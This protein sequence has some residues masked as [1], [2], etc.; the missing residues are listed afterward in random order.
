VRREQRH[1]DGNP[2]H[3]ATLPLFTDKARR[4]PRNAKRPRLT[5]A[6]L[7][8]LERETGFEPA[9]LSEADG[10]L[11]TVREVAAR[12]RVSTATVYKLCRRGVLRHVRVLNAV[13]IAAR[14]L[15]AL[16]ATGRSTTPEQ[17]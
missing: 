9:T 10:R 11:L 3:A 6:P 4:L 12:L 7:E 15:D 17:T 2:R 16:A 14:D 8:K 5:A 13:R 1:R